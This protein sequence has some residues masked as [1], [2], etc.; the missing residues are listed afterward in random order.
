MPFQTVEE[1][2][3]A[4]NRPWE[5]VYAEF[6]GCN[7]LGIAHELPGQKKHLSEDI[8]YQIM[9]QQEAITPEYML[10]LQVDGR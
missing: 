7:P 9:K 3:T 2:E 6:S 5:S 4:L 10:L 1:I 8:W